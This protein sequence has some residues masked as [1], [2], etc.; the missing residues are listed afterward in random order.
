M[1]LHRDLNHGMRDPAILQHPAEA[2]TGANQQRDGG[3]GGKALVAE[4]QDGIARYPRMTPSVIKLMSTPIRRAMSSLPMNRRAWL[5]TLSFGC[6]HVSPTSDKHQ[7]DGKKD[8]AHGEPEAGKFAIRIVIG[9]VLGHGIFGG[10][11][12][13]GSN[14]LR[15]Q[16]PRKRG[17]WNRDEYRIENRAAHIGMVK[18]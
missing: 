4:S 14:D 1:P 15:E 18:Y 7:R 13:P 12:D 10:N 9:E 2:T 5:A 17:C 6:E 8:A 16:W 11:L 3:R